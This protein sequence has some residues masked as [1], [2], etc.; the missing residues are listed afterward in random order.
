MKKIFFTLVMIIGLLLPNNV[1]A[2]PNPDNYTTLNL[3]EAITEENN[4]LR[5][6]TGYTETTLTINEV[7]D[8]DSQ[9]TVYAFIGFGCPH[10]HDLLEFLNEIAPEYDSKFKLVAFETWNSSVADENTA[11]MGELQDFL[12]S[13][14]VSGNQAQGYSV[15]LIL[16][17]DHFFTGYG[18]SDEEKEA[19]KEA[20]D[21]E[22]EKT[23]KNRYDVFKEM[24]K[25]ENKKNIELIIP[26]I[27]AVICSTVIIIL[28][29]NYQ[30][31]KIHD[32]IDKIYLKLG[33]EIENEDVKKSLV[34]VQK[35]TEPK[36]VQKA[37][38]P[39][40]YDLKKDTKL[41]NSQIKSKNK[42]KK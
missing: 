35:V 18:A 42:S 5:G 19:I 27:I 4:L 39:N 31:N 8:N 37:E 30:N 20:I 26:S 11:L 3:V 13:N 1:L 40:D 7:D 32:R 12:G 36:K 41:S 2:A 14:V 38:E 24:K 23:P 25:A 9:V 28:F 10:C 21:T 17:G 29:I 33:I 15:P 22:Y 16:I 6:E 34:K